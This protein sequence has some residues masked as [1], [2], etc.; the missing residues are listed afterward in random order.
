MSFLRKLFRGDARDETPRRD[1]TDT[2]VSASLNTMSELTPDKSETSGLV[3]PLHE[4]AS[5]DTSDTSILP[6]PKP[7]SNSEP[8]TTQPSTESESIETP[9][10]SQ[11]AWW[12]ES[13]CEAG[14][15][16][17][18]EAPSKETA[19]LTQKT[20][21]SASARNQS[22][23]DEVPTRSK[24]TVPLVDY[25]ENEVSSSDVSDHQ[26]K[27]S[28]HNRQEDASVSDVETGSDSNNDETQQLTDG[29]APAVVQ[30]RSQRGFA[31]A[32]LRDV[33][34]VRTI[35]QDSVYA[36]TSS[37]PRESQDIMM[38]LFIIADG[39]GGHD[40]GEIASR[41]AVSSVVRQVLADLVVPAVTDNVTESLQS[42]MILAVQEANRTIWDYARA[43]GSDMGTTCTAALVLGNGV[44]VAHVG[45]SRAYLRTPTGMQCITADHSTVGRLI[46]VGQLDPEE[47]R[48][49]PLRSQ[50]YR[51]VGQSPDV[52]VDF[53]YQ[54]IGDAI[55]LLV[56][57]DGLWGML[58]EDVIIDVLDHSIWPQDACCELIARANL[59]GG[60]DNISAVVVTFPARNV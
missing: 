2:P 44:Y 58:D 3:D 28:P 6:S 7:P 33:G 21:E 15:D 53:T 31:A 39:M 59:A 5:S 60:E 43:N 22:G 34:R 9:T 36:L 24:G 45:D 32:V 23:D 49:H 10:A 20:R 38:G 30:L 25:T 19:P 42:L 4:K 35:N 50:L 18:V 16:Q 54:P 47:A 8:E 37:I 14:K 41:L 48:D 55:Q 27:A 29:I 11:E 51:T 13:S 56:C 40:G 12:E 1:K 57:S 46:E 52:Q 26:S 17:S